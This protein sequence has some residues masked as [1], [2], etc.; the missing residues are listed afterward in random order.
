MGKMKTL[1][2]YQKRAV[3]YI[4]KNASAALF[5]EMRLGK[6]VITIESLKD[7]KELILIICP[8]SVI[9]GWWEEIERAETDAPFDVINY[10][11]LKNYTLEPKTIV[12][13]E[14]VRIKNPKAQ[15]TKLLLQQFSNVSQ[16]ILLSGNPAP[17]TPLEYFT[18]MQFLHNE[19]M[20]CRN[21]WQFRNRYFTSD[22]KGFQ[23]WPKAGTKDKIKSMLAQD[24]FVLSRKDVGMESRKIYEKRYVEMPL[25]VRQIYTKL[26]KDF[27]AKFPDGKELELDNILVQLNY[28][29]QVSNGFIS[30]KELSDFK[31]RELKEL[32]DGELKDQQVIIWTNYRW[33]QEMI[34]KSIPDCSIING[35]TALLVRQKICERFN[36]GEIQNL[37]MSVAC[38]KFGLNLAR[39]STAIYFSNSYSWDDRSQS[40]ER[41]FLPTKQEPLLYVDLITK[42]SIEEDILKAL[43]NKHKQSKYFLGEIIEN[44]RTR[45]RS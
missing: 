34:R 10:E 35:D 9:P 20:G 1:Y 18:Q 4:Q 13:D 33:E 44:T 12:I 38:G 24:A 17:N 6:T 21:Y 14:S 22:Y 16:K 30:N 42:D 11:Q 3:Q 45:S 37:V 31:V 40:E 25:K 8:K 26:E 19:W 2:P 41:I 29:Q 43:K 7:E 27:V 5:M 39:S 23:W 36:E 28:L 32:L 15:I